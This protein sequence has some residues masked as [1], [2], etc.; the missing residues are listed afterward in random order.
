[1]IYDPSRLALFLPKHGSL[2]TVKLT[3]WQL[4]RTAQEDLAGKTPQL[5]RVIPLKNPLF[6][7]MSEDA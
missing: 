4:W 7:K 2:S 1:L 6:L 5:K 3:Q